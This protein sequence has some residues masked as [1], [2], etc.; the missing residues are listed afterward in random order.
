MHPFDQRLFGIGSKNLLS[1]E[2]YMS[3]SGELKAVDNEKI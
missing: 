3:S 1:K 2:N